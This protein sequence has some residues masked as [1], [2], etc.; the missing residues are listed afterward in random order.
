MS[1]IILWGGCCLGAI[2]Q[3][4]LPRGYCPDTIWSVAPWQSRYS[5]RERIPIGRG[6]DWGCTMLSSPGVYTWDQKF[7]TSWQST[8]QPTRGD[9]GQQSCHRLAGAMLRSSNGEV[10]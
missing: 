6:N 4:I 3:G 10:D 9:P 8:L 2:V 7:T 1:L 5:Q